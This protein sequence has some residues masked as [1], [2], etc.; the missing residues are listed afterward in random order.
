MRNNILN[1]KDYSKVISD[2]C[3]DRYNYPDYKDKCEKCGRYKNDNIEEICTNI[4]SED[5]EK[6]L[7][8]CKQIQEKVNSSNISVLFEEDNEDDNEENDKSKV[9]KT[10]IFTTSF[11]NEYRTSGYV[12]VIR[13]KVKIRE[14]ILED[15][16]L[17]VSSRFDNG[18]DQK[19][20]NYV[21]AKAFDKTGRIF[22]DLKPMSS[23]DETWDALLMY[24]Y[25]DK[26]EE[27][28]KQGMFRQ[29]ATFEYNDS[30]AKGR[31]DVSRHIKTNFINNGKIAYATREYTVNNHINQLILMA[32]EYLKRRYGILF[33]DQI[34]SNKILKM[35]YK[36]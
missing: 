18:E 30:K 29:Y 13:T 7:N 14:E 11:K 9:K 28:F 26:L 23:P 3:I 1:L 4:K 6:L 25:I 36:F 27:A 33:E 21:F 8:I 35:V 10:E 32:Y 24:M 15:I 17:S 19:F 20:L 2:K 22:K 34:N 31:L 12:G 16:T 5:D